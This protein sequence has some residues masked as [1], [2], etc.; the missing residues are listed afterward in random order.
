MILGARTAAWSGATTGYH[1]VVV[2][3]DLNDM[4]EI[5]NWLIAQGIDKSA[6]VNLSAKQMQLKC[7]VNIVIDSSG[8][9]GPAKIWDIRFNYGSQK[10]LV[11]VDS[12]TMSGSAKPGFI[13]KDS[14]LL[15]AP[16]DAPS[17]NGGYKCLTPRRSY[18]RSARPSA[19]FCSTSR[20]W[21][22]AA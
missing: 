17:S 22:V 20:R 21:E 7:V 1:T 12:G 5:Y 4:V 16:I 11:V 8:S 14:V 3:R 9:Y 19:R 2:D 13:A 6:V 10:G 15:V 18:R